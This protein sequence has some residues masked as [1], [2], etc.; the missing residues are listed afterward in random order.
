MPWRFVEM[1]GRMPFSDFV[2]AHALSE[3]T[4]GLR[5]LSADRGELSAAS[6]NQLVSAVHRLEACWELLRLGVGEGI[7]QRALDRL[8][9]LS[10]ELAPVADDWSVQHTLLRLAQQSGKERSRTAME[11]V[12][13]ALAS[14]NVRAKRA[15]PLHERL[16]AVFEVDSCQWRALPLSGFDE[17]AVLDGF[18]RCYESGRDNGQRAL[19]GAGEPAFAHWARWARATFHQLDLMRPALGA[20]NR[21]R[22]WC[23]SRVNDGFDKQ[24]GLLDVRGRL[25]T[26]ALP[27]KDRI[28]V[29]ALLETGLDECRCRVTKLF[30]HSY[31]PTP[32]QFRDAVWVD[33]NRFAY[34]N[35]GSW[36]SSWPRSA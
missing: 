36:A 16:S 21:A 17:N 28:R 1:Y 18:E 33:A 5:M 10:R 6:L 23:L 14:L 20:D 32:R 34:E 11:S 26:I 13:G 2:V 8:A 15:L 12:A 31:G 29:E 27:I 7:Y 4:R 9:A 25:D 24:R 19:D 3:N 22:R 30:A 35:S